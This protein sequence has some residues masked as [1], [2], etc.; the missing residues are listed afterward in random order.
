[1]ITV[2]VVCLCACIFI[3]AI[4][5]NFR[6]HI[7]SISCYLF[8]KMDGMI[9]SHTCIICSDM[10]ESV[11]LALTLAYTWRYVLIVQCTVRYRYHSDTSAPE[12]LIS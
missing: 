9:A 12:Q 2:C 8:V 10:L 11:G 3:G 5:S 6:K 1:M 4:L 7:H